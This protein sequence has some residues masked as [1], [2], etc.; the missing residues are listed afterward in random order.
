MGNRQCLTRIR[1]ILL[2]IHRILTILL[3]V[4]GLLI[5]RQVIN[6]RYN[7]IKPASVVQL[8]RTS[9]IMRVVMSSSPDCSEN[10]QIFTPPLTLVVNIEVC[11][12]FGAHYQ[13]V[14]FISAVQCKKT[15]VI[16]VFTVSLRMQGFVRMTEVR[17]KPASLLAE[18]CHAT[19]LLW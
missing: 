5:D 2:W 8:V 7:V 14:R 6:R 16:M 9:S 12:W 11:K 17:M 19:W 18:R 10:F 13:E 3:N 4:C 1:S 15:L